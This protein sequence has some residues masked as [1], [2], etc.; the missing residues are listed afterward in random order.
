MNNIAHQR[1]RIADAIEKCDWSG[2]PIG[3][4]EILRA[5]IVALRSSP[6]DVDVVAELEEVRKA[7]F[8]DVGDEPDIYPDYDRCCELAGKMRRAI[9]AVSTTG[10]ENG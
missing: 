1:Q 4:K 3:N 5:A 6:I 7:V 2:C 8:G 9:A 10:G